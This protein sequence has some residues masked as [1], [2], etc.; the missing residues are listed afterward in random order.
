MPR[1]TLHRAG[2]FLSQPARLLEIDARLRAGRHPS[3]AELAS[4]LGVSA[5]TIQ[6]DFDYLRFTLGAPLEYDER[7]KGWSYTEDT[8]SLPAVYLTN[9]D[10]Q[11]LLLVRQAVEQYQGTPYAAAAHHALELMERALPARERLAAEWVS[12]RVAFTD[13]PAATIRPAVWKAVLEGLRTSHT[14]ALT[15]QRPGAKPQRRRVDPYGL[16]VSEGDWYLY[17]YSHHHKARRTFLLARM[18]RVTVLQASFDLPEG[19]SLA[20]Y[21]HEGFGG[22]QADG[23]RA[24]W[25]RITFT[26]NASRVAAERKWHPDQRMSWD[27]RKRLTIEFEVRAPFRLA[28][29]LLE[30]ENRIEALSWH[31]G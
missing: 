3:H 8:Y 7:R 24:R 18:K 26:E 31:A 27:T 1:R 5:R 20:R 2:D 29:R 12:Q 11:A 6:R 23:M 9:D 4:E 19:F 15:Y 28:R 13:F 10:V 22:L 30:W 17:T 25:V 16:I 14:L 21:V